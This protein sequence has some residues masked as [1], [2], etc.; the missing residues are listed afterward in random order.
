MIPLEWANA[1]FAGRIFSDAW[2]NASTVNKTKALATAETQIKTLSLNSPP[3]GVYREAICLQALHL[4][5]LS[6]SDRERSRAVTQGVTSRRVGDA[7]ET[8]NKSHC[9]L[10]DP[11]ALA[12]L[13]RYFRRRS[14]GIR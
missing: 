4:L 11:E 13:K 14:G 8:Y 5:E 1:Y 12:V 10:I 7:G 2:D 9:S 3:A 6:D